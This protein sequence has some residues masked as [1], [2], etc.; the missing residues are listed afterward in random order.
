MK[1]TILL[2]TLA[3]SLNAQPPAISDKAKLEFAEARAARMQAQVAYDGLPAQIKKLLEDTLQAVNG[4]EQALQ[5]AVTKLQ[6]ECGPGH[7]P[8]QDPKEGLR[9]EPKAILANPPAK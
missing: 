1:T 9:C 3:L 8:A 4:A 5:N 2:L 6:A 7:Q